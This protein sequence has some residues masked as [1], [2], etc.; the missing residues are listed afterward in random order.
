MH[1]QGSVFCRCI[2]FS[3]FLFVLYQVVCRYIQFSFVDSALSAIYTYLLVILYIVSSVQSQFL[4][5]MG[6]WSDIYTHDI[7]CTMMVL[8]LNT[9]S[10]R[11]NFSRV[12]YFILNPWFLM[13]QTCFAQNW[14]TKV[15]SVFFLVAF[16]HDSCMTTTNLYCGLPSYEAW[17]SVIIHAWGYNKS[18]PYV[19]LY[20]WG[21]LY[22]PQFPYYNVTACM[23][24]CR[25]ALFA[26]WFPDFNLLL[27]FFYS[28][29]NSNLESYRLHG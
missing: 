22:I 28:S 9:P 1:S 21:R 4:V 10:K 23:F 14:V 2:Q 6:Q 27:Q 24:L 16:T 26:W 3:Y 13:L 20:N 5:T 25:I 19:S 12:F 29:N 8:H 15:W 18:E 11:W 17:G 7:M